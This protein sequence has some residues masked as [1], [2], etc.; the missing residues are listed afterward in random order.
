MSLDETL[1]S[2]A[3]PDIQPEYKRNPHNLVDL[4]KAQ[5]DEETIQ[6]YRD[7]GVAKNKLTG[8]PEKP[9]KYP[10]WE[11]VVQDFEVD[12]P[13]P[14]YIPVH[15]CVGDA[16]Y[17]RTVE[18][19]FK[20]IENNLYYSKGFSYSACGTIEVNYVR[21][22]G[23]FIVTKGQH[24][25]IAAWLALGEGAS[26]PASVKVCG[27]YS[28]EEQIKAEAHDHHVDA[29]KVTRQKAHQSG[30]S[31]FIAGDKEEVKY[32]EWILSRG[33]GIKGK[34]HLFPNLQYPRICETPWAVRSAIQ[35]NEANCSQALKL[36]NR[37][38]PDSDT[39]I[40][41]KSIKAVTQFLTLLQEKIE[42]TAN[43]NNITPD[44][45]VDDVFCYIFK[46]RKIKTA[47]WLK[48][49]NA[50]RGENI[51]IPLGRLIRFT[52][53]YCQENDIRLPDGR[54]TEDSVWCSVNENFWVDFLNKTTPKELHG[55]VNAIVTE[56]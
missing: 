30:L 24:R 49:S 8:N 22:T 42:K 51:I 56:C 2:L 3:N 5:F 48:G 55:S 1:S 9:I 38:L 15:A 27:E 35:I 4:A 31:G 19:N 26:I 54:K 47:A 39:I 17:N 36:L 43:I 6:K 11:T 53:S 12:S 52:N 13:T 14:A 29:Q 16:S 32:T 44:Q 45:F 23:Q 21:E 50:L 41:G 40:N 28:E 37:Y 7:L 33:I 18:I 20:S 46:G 34:M 25:V 10:F